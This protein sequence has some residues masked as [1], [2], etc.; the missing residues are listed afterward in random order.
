[1]TFSGEKVQILK[2]TYR[3]IKNIALSVLVA[4]K[5]ESEFKKYFGI[6]YISMPL[7]V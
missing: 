1:M 2:F 3:T 5:Y 6:E 7:L 4:L